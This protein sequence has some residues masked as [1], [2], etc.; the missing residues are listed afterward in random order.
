MKLK[1]TLTIFYKLFLLLPYANFR[2]SNFSYPLVVFQNEQSPFVVGI[3]GIFIAIFWSFPG[4][5]L[6]LHSKPAGGLEA[7]ETGTSHMFSTTT[8]SSTPDFSEDV[9]F[10]TIYACQD[11]RLQI[12][13]LDGYTINIVRANY[14]RFSIAVCN[15]VGRTDFS[16]NCMS[17]GSLNILKSR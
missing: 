8:A 5:L 7:S 15:E 13:C 2:L 4:V 17:K 9:V 3:Q 1:W 6:L 10:Q 14:G 12:S 11:E 16:V